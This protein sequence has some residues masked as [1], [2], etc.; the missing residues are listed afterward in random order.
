MSNIE[1][2]YLREQHRRYPTPKSPVIK[3][4]LG[5]DSNLVES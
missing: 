1:F 4:N 2:N 5:K 3:N